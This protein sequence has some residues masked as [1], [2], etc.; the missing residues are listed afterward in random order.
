MWG[1]F[2]DKYMDDLVKK[3]LI[4]L[5]PLKPKVYEGCQR[6]KEEQPYQLQRCL[7]AFLWAIMAI[8]NHYNETL[9]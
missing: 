4:G 7:W 1:E 8:G 5:F 6:E 2:F 3:L 9:G